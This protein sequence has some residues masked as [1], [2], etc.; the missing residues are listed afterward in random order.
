[1]SRGQQTLSAFEGPRN[2]ADEARR[3]VGLLS[4]DPAR[5][6]ARGRR[7]DRL[8]HL[9]GG[10]RAGREGR[11]AVD[12]MFGD[13][14]AILT[15]PATGE[16]PLGL[17]STGKATFNLLWTYLW[18]PCVTLPLTRGRTGLPVGIQ[19][20]GR[21]HEDARLLDIAAW[22]NRCCQSN[23]TR[24][25]PPPRRSRAIDAGTLTSEALVRACLDRI[26]E[27]EPLRQGLGS[28]STRS[29]R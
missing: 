13:I 29:W 6:Q 12:A 18:M 22:A 28:I 2:H 10:A 19:L 14:D 27:R 5:R 20:V 25:S 1:M 11:A 26:A 15:A 23:R 24:R 7:Q 17:Q 21:R 3:H 9:H 16:A 4:D 8:C